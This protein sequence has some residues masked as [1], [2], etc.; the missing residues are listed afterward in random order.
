M[1]RNSLDLSDSFLSITPEGFFGLSFLSWQ[2]NKI[3][4]DNS[5]VFVMIFHI[6][7][8]LSCIFSFL[9]KDWWHNK[10][11]SNSIIFIKGTQLFGIF[12]V[13]LMMFRIM[14][15]TLGDYPNLWEL[16]PLNF[17][18]LFIL[19]I[20]ISLAIRKIEY[21]KYF[22][23]F[24][25]ISGI[26][27]MYITNLSNSEYW[28]QFGG[29]EIGYDNYFFWDY[30]II[31]SSSVVL[32]FFIM[33]FLK[34]TFYKKEV[35]YFILVMSVIT[36]IIFL[37]NL[38]LSKSSNPRWRA[39]W[40]FLG[41][42]EVNEVVLDMLSFLG[43]LVGYP[44]ILFTFIVFGIIFYSLSTFIYLNSDRVIFTWYKDHKF[45]YSI[46]PDF[47]PSRNMYYFINGEFPS[48]I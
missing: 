11:Q 6:I 33:T 22:A 16:I 10:Y 21:A 47:V 2:G 18:K 17:N 25:I 34:P 35:L 15:L 19:L 40:F 44:T 1:V 31:H 27:G 39:N 30:F 48:D 37:L 43:P 3:T 32:P 23:I 4:Y 12:I 20:S 46:H 29:V 26:M 9:S 45:H 36:I 28:S 41:I 13:F 7:V 38:A 8:I 14:V 5:W 24:S 42:P